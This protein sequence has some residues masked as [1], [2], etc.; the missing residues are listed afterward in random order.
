MNA[1]FVINAPV[2]II[3]AMETT[4][5]VGAIHESPAVSISLKSKQYVILSIAKNLANR[6]GI[7]SSL[8]EGAVTVR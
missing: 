5:F 8:F 7:F 1:E 4:N 3:N 6:V 2:A